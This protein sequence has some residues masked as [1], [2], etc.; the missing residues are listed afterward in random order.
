[1]IM[2]HSIDIRAKHILRASEP[3]KFLPNPELAQNSY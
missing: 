3:R 1:M 2:S